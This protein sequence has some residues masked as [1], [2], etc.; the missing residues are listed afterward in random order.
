MLDVPAKDGWYKVDEETAIPLGSKESI[1]SD[2][3]ARYWYGRDTESFI[4]AVVRGALGRRQEAGRQRVLLAGRCLRGGAAW[5]S[6]SR[7]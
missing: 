1:R 3:D 2:P 6:Q 4:G 7:A 5:P